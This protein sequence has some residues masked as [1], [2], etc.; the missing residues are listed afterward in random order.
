[1]GSATS[2]LASWLP[3]PERSD[4]VNH[5]TE[6]WPSHPPPREALRAKDWMRAATVPPRHFLAHA[7]RPQMGM[8]CHLASLQRL[9]RT[10]R[11]QLLA[12]LQ[13]C[14]P[15]VEV[16]L[17]VQP[18]LCGCA[19]EESLNLRA[20]SGVEMR[21]PFRMPVTSAS[22][23]LDA[24]RFCRPFRRRSPLTPQATPSRVASP[25]RPRPGSTRGGR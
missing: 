25:T 11:P 9:V 14:L 5:A 13:L 2:P 3:P 22:V 23:K 17:Q 4:V 12:A 18:E 16:A 21:V 6:P 20:V 24:P 19:C 7:M 10:D 15:E 1:M 8:T